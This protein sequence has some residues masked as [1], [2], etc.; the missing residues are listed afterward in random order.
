MLGDYA[1]A[2]GAR[3]AHFSTIGSTMDEAMARARNG[4]AGHL[5]VIADE[6]TKGRGRHGRSW[7]SE[8]GNLYASLLLIDPCPPRCA[9]QLGFV[10]GIALQ[11]ALAPLLPAPHKIALKWP[12]D[13]L[14]DGAKVAGIL[15]EGAQLA[16]GAQ[17][18]VIGI[19][20]NIAVQPDH[21][22]YPVTSLR[23]CHVAADRDSVFAALSDAMTIRLAQWRAGENFAAMRLDW[24]KAAAGIG[25]MVE[26]RQDESTQKGI[27]REIDADG[28]MVLDCGGRRLLVHAGDVYLNRT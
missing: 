14:I 25:T 21:V 23:R 17:A 28:R 16:N 20:V 11:D 24:M 2:A 27:F 22:A 9:P 3:V 15:L 6:Q 8:G 4:D 7:I 5:W 19:G 18:V 26:V 10:A 12:N 13:A 1:A